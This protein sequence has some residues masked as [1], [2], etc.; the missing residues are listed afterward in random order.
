[1]TNTSTELYSIGYGRFPYLLIRNAAGIYTQMPILIEYNPDARE[2]IVIPM[3]DFEDIDELIEKVYLVWLDIVFGRPVF[4]SNRV[5]RQ[6]SLLSTHSLDYIE[7]KNTNSTEACLVLGKDDCYYFSS[8]HPS[9]K[10]S[11]SIPKGGSLWSMKFEKIEFNEGSHYY[12]E[13]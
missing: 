13:D 7:M 6:P 5:L 11:N 8:E 9:I 1:M 4:T 12:S 10:P 2:G 3:E